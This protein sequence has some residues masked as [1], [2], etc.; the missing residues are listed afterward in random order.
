MRFPSTRT[1]AG[2]GSGSRAQRVA[3][4]EVVLLDGDDVG[5][6]RP[7]LELE[8]EAQRLGRLVADGH[9]ILHPIADEP[10]AHDRERVLRQP[11]RKRVAQIEGGREVLDLAEGEEQRPLS[12][13]A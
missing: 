13:D 10:L 2:G 6:V 11:A 8:L 1:Y 7:H 12:V 3:E 4:S 5:E 9:V